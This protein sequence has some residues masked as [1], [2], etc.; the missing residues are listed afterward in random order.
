MKKYMLILFEEENMYTDFSP[1][2]MQKE[3]GEHMKWIE[4]LGDHYDSGEPL[5][6]HAKS[7]KG[8]DKVVTDGPY[9]ESKELVSGFYILNAESLDEATELSKGCPVLRLGGNIE[10]REV[11]KM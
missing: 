7:V 1:E 10:V 5:M 9:I 2:E 6:P 11:M 4:T 3:I 8:K